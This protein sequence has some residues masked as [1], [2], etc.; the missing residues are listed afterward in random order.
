MS[1]RPAWPMRTS[2][3]SCLSQLKNGCQAIRNTLLVL[4]PHKGA[5]GTTTAVIHISILSSNFII[6]Y[7]GCLSR[8]S[9]D[10]QGWCMSGCDPV[11]V[12]KVYIFPHTKSLCAHQPWQLHANEN[13]T[14][15]LGNKPERSWA[16]LPCASS[17][18]LARAHTA[19]AK[20]AQHFAHKETSTMMQLD[21]GVC[22][23]TMRSCE[24]MK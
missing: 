4:V 5:H 18:I 23:P 8:I 21:A 2:H 22:K 14:L 11:T 13:L 3:C 7:G 16:R 17:H 1:I 12:E 15:A 24:I 9:S 10:F 20:F 19:L 6:R